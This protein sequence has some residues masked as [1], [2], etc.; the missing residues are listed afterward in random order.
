MGLH[1]IRA[2][3]VLAAVLALGVA[4]H[5]AEP[6]KG[7]ILKLGTLGGSSSFAHAINNAN[8]VVGVSET[9]EGPQFPPGPGSGKFRRAFLWQEGTMLDL[10]T[11]GGH[12]SSAFAINDEGQVVGA[13]QM[14]NGATHATLWRVGISGATDLGVLPG[15]TTSV[16]YA[17][18]D[19]GQVVGQ[20]N[21]AD[22]GS[23]AFLWENGVMTDLTPNSEANTV[24]TDI[25]NQGEVCGYRVQGSVVTAMLWH[26]GR[27]TELGTLPANTN[28]RASALNDATQ[29]VGWAFRGD[30]V[31][32]RGFVW[33]DGQAREM[34]KLGGRGCY[35]AAINTAG[36]VVGEA[37]N[38]RR[39]SRAF[40]WRGRGRLIDLNSLL[41]R[42]PGWTLQSATGIN[43]AGRIVG[44]G[45]HGGPS[46]YLLSP[47]GVPPL[48]PPPPPG[49]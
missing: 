6:Q 38:A 42:K 43:D 45:D 1:R 3:A 47:P 16:A 40:L 22:G 25:N 5:A 2:G 33:Q 14:E 39:A 34:G 28:S 4:P 20:S 21:T 11:L 27:A 41:P 13:A 18:N 26:D 30:S 32:S 29:L 37:E 9:A 44:N 48:P 24:A 8:Q 12:E 49:S 19:L 15:G 31:K 36:H 35:P 23:H 17:I 7:S 46:A 10:G